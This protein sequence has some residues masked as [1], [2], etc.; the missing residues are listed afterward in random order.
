MSRDTPAAAPPPALSPYDWRVWK[1]IPDER[2]YSG[3]KIDEL[4]AEYAAHLQAELE[5]RDKVLKEIKTEVTSTEP[6]S[7]R[8]AIERLNKRAEAA[9]ARCRVLEEAIQP[10]IGRVS[11]N[12]EELDVHITV[13]KQEFERLRE[14]LAPG[15]EGKS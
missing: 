9:A 4:L 3:T 2:S 7:I 15:Q 10:F 12:L 1:G 11:A 5:R 8:D 6:G 13:T 14:A